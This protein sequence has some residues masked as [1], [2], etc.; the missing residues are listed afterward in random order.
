MGVFNVAWS[1][2]RALL[3]LRLVLVA[4]NND[5]QP[6]SIFRSVCCQIH[7]CALC[8]NNMQRPDL[9][10]PIVTIFNITPEKVT[11]GYFFI[12]P[13]QQIQDVPHIYDNY[14]V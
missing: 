7:P 5:T 3:L 2:T 13:Y 12:A 11:P 10:A 9:V 4:A 6:T 8:L 14:G 1:I